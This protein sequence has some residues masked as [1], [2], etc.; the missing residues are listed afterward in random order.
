MISPSA[1]NGFDYLL[2]QSLKGAL[3]P[4][5]QDTFECVEVED[6]AQAKDKKIVILTT[7]S[8]LFRVIAM[9]YFT[10]DN[11]TRQFLALM[12]NLPTANMTDTVFYDVM[13]E[14][15][16]I[17]CGILNRELAKYFPHMGMSTPNFMERQCAQYIE[18]L[19]GGHV[20]HVKVTIN[21]DWSFYSSLCVCDHANL[22]FSVDI[23]EEE[24]STGELE[25][26]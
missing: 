26:F 23:Y 15:G 24:A 10:P 21:Q 18:K 22:D 16:N 17:F 3:A 11:H 14:R 20:R 13:A 5:E 4:N 7:A 6:I 9:I 8:Y 2:K 19:E 1:C 12:N 25:M